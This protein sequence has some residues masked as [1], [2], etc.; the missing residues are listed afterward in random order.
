MAEA[1]RPFSVVSTVIAAVLA[2]V[3]PWTGEERLA[4][5]G[6]HPQMDVTRVALDPADPA[7][8]RVGGL[9]FL[10]GVQ[11]R[12]RDP[13]FGGFSSLSVDGDRFTLLSDRG[14]FIR[15]RMGPDWAPHG[16]SFASLPAGPGTGWENRDR[17]SESMTRDPATGRV[18]VGFED[19][20][21]V[22]R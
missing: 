17:D 21:M 15:F 13:A 5:L 8:V 14:N 9:T 6:D 3:P 12:S 10:G 16:L 22:W 18:W 19:S 4:L 1:M 2:L 7:R 20:N 11:L